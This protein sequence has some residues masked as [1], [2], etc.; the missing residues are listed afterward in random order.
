MIGANWKTAARF[1][2]EYPS[3]A[4]DAEDGTLYLG[5]KFG[6]KYDVLRVRTLEDGTLVNER[7]S[8]PAAWDGIESA[9]Y[10]ELDRREKEY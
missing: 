9:A 10:A 6:D 3:R 5:W 7:I 8:E 4:K 2:P 1:A